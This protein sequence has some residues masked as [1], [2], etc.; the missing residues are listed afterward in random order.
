MYFRN[1]NW[2]FLEKKGCAP[3]VKDIN[4]QSIPPWFQ[5]DFTPGLLPQEIHWCQTTFFPQIL[6]HFL[7]FLYSTL[8]GI[9]ID[10]LNRGLR[11]FFMGKPICL[12][13]SNQ[14]ITFFFYQVI[15]LCMSLVLSCC[16]KPSDHILSVVSDTPP[17]I[18]HWRLCNHKGTGI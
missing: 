16:L 2:D 18:P 3:N 13:F 6:A 10:T 1:F 11:V 9:S 14:S 8:P 5:I 17:S 4:N 15:C 7:E 12:P